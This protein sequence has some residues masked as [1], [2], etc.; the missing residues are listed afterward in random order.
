MSEPLGV[1]A[2]AVSDTQINVSWYTSEDVKDYKVYR[3]HSLI[4]EVT[5]TAIM[6]TGLSER[7]NYC[8]S[9]SNYYA[10]GYESFISAEACA[11]TLTAPTVPIGLTATI[12]SSTQI[13]LSWIAPTDNAG[14]LGY[15][16]YRNDSYV[17][18]VT[19]T[20]TSDIGLSEFNN[21]CYKVSA[22]YVGGKES[23]KSDQVC[24]SISDTTAPSI[25]S[26]LTAMPVST[27]WVDLSWSASTDNVGVAGYKIYRDD[28]YITS[29]VGLKFSDK[30][31]QS[32]T[33]YSYKIS[34]YD[35]AGNESDKTNNVS[36]TTY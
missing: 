1:T 36:V 21:Y 20:S 27:Y 15:N 26:G 32:R 9:V 5:T 19:T 22:Y 34:A 18:F 13:N 16:V 29:V 35:A 8:Y 11:I 28:S 6:D 31:L 17:K 25:P 4:K 14:L 30:N 12:V 7:T 23:A 24:A 10:G 3:D 33:S 2:T